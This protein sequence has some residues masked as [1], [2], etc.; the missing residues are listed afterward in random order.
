MT[1]VVQENKSLW[2]IKNEYAKDAEGNPELITFWE[3]SATEKESTIQQLTSL[4]KS[5]S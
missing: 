1:Q 3:K 4:L 2:R 5:I